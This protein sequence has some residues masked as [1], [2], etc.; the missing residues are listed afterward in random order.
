MYSLFFYSFI[1]YHY[2]LLLPVLL[3][4]KYS[5]M[6]MMLFLIFVCFE[7]DNRYCRDAT[8][9]EERRKRS[10]ENVDR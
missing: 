10:K 4:D 1:T 9:K 7:V 5:M 3:F 6:M 8:K 2:Y